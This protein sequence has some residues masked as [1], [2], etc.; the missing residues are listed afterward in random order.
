L[1]VCFLAPFITPSSL[2]FR[3]YPLSP[4][5]FN[6]PPFVPLPGKTSDRSCPFFPFIFNPSFIFFPTLF[7]P[8]KFFPTC[9]WS[10]LFL[11]DRLFFHPCPPSYNSMSRR[12]C[13]PTRPPCLPGSYFPL[14]LD[15]LLFLPRLVNS[16]LTT[17]VSGPYP[18]DC[19]CVDTLFSFWN[20]SGVYMPPF[21]VFPFS[22]DFFLPPP[23]SFPHPNRP[24]RCF[25][26]RTKDPLM[27][28][29]KFCPL[30]YELMPFARD[31]FSSPS[32]FS[33]QVFAPPP[34]SPSSVWFST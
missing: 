17:F 29:P 21:R 26:P 14:Y 25:L 1:F 18:A 4:P 27:M 16:E 19:P 32:F 11:P 10:F 31:Q 12:W 33:S 6:N 13:T 9:R 34:F 24:T 7:H 8:P 3:H 30:T 20:H 2:F 22:V 5:D 28:F 15:F 23:E